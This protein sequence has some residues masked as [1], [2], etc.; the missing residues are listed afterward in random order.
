MPASQ[1]TKSA[2]ILISGSGSNLQAIIDTWRQGQLPLEIS[3]VISNKR[4]AA[5]LQH[6][7]NAN[8]PTCILEHTDYSS[9]QEYDKALLD[10]INSYGAQLVILAGFMRILTNNFVN[11]FPGRLIN[12][13]PS[14]LPQFRGLNTHQRVL[15]AGCRHHGASVHFVTPDLDEGPVIMQAQVD[16]EAK[17][18]ANSLAAR[19]LQL[20]HVIY[21]LTIRLIAQDRIVMTNHTILLDGR[22]LAHPLLY[23]DCLKY[24]Q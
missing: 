20:E 3:A 13:H 17:D 22:R 14:L 10:L 24:L 18:D 9:R 2:V 8:I 4:D 21:P 11:Q 23:P 12:I 5:G 15:D 6:A 19:V 7:I 1:P 16:V